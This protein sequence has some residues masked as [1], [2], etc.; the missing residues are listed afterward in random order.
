MKS[1]IALLSLLSFGPAVTQSQAEVS[2]SFF[3]DQLEPYGEW[4]ETGDYGYVWHPRDVR[5]DWRPYTDGRWAYTDAGWTWVSEEPYSWAVYH[6]GRWTNLDRVGW[7]WVP[8]TDWGPAWVSW[9]SSERHVGWAP[10]PPEATLSVGVS[11]GAWADSY[12]DIGPASYTFVETRNLG[13]PRIFSVARPWRE[14]ITYINETR[15]ITN[16]SYQNNFVINQG[17]RYEDITRVSEQPIQRLRLERRTDFA[18]NARTE[19]AFRTQ[20]QGE[21]LAVA[22]PTITRTGDAVPKRCLLYTS[23]SPRDRQKS[24]MPS[25]A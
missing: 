22:A 13:A 14:N 4:M 10:L 15:N 6:Y 21:T 5:E 25:S 1:T 12:Y 7:V 3:Y 16:I 11:I 18:A 24:R 2:V 23:P 9:R 19:G 20:V 17:P 8:G